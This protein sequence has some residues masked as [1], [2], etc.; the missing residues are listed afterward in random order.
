ME[1]L[2]K[3]KTAC[4]ERQLREAVTNFWGTGD[5]DMQ[6]LKSDENNLKY[7]TEITEKPSQHIC[8]DLG[9]LK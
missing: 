1:A 9:L 7:L 5:T 2:V 3:P 8:S 6:G 4:K